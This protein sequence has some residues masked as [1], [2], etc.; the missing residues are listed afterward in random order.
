[1]VFILGIP[2]TLLL[3]TVPGLCIYSLLEDEI[4]NSFSLAVRWAFVLATSVTL[5]TLIMVLFLLMDIFPVEW[6]AVF[7]AVLLVVWIVWRKIPWQDFI[8]P[9]SFDSRESR[10]KIIAAVLVF[11]IL[12]LIFCQPTEYYFGGRDPGIYAGTAVQLSRLGRLKVEDPLLQG[13]KENYPD[14]F[15]DV[16]LKFPG[17]FMERHGDRYY[18]NPQFFHGYTAWLATGHRFFGFDGF[19]YMTPIL[20]L[21]SMLVIYAVVSSLWSRRTGFLTVVLLGLNIA[22]IWYARGPYSE[23]HSQLITWFS[24]F[25]IVQ[26]WKNKHDLM[27]L[28][29]GLTIGTALLVRLDNIFVA[30]PVGLSL[31]FILAYDKGKLGRWIW[32]FILSLA[33]MYLIF[34]SYALKF[35]RDYAKHLLILRSPI[36]NSLSLRNLFILLGALSV[37][38]VMIVI[39]LRNQW[40]KLI[41]WL[42]G[43]RKPIALVIGVGMVLL[44]G[45]LYFVRPLNPNRNLLPEGYYSFR[46]ESLV[47]LGWYISP[48]G[49]LLAL[50]GFIDFI[51]NKFRKQHIFPMLFMLTFCTMY[52]YNPRI[53]PDHFWAVRRYVPMIIPSFTIFMAYALDRISRLTVGKIKL[54]PLSLAVT[55]LLCIFLIHEARPFL[56]HTEYGGTRQGVEELASYFDE[57]DLIITWDAQVTPRL[58]GTPLYL[59]YGKN[60]LTVG[61]SFNGENLARFIEDKK[62]EGWD[63]YFL[64]GLDDT[65]M[66]ELPFHLEYKDT[67]EFW[68][69]SAEVVEDRKPEN[70]FTNI[71]EVNIYEPVEGSISWEDSLE[72]GVIDIGNPRDINYRL[73]GFYG[74][75]SSG[76][77]DYRWSGPRALVELTLPEE[78][79]VSQAKSLTIRGRHL[80]PPDVLTEK[81]E[82]IVN[83]QSI[84]SVDMG[85]EFQEYTLEIPENLLEGEEKI[86]IEFIT[87][88]WKPQELGMGADTR[89][90]GFMLDYIRFED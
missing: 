82:V 48:L 24:I 13:L 30:I 18:T 38:G 33:A 29:A 77:E 49:I 90:L 72:E 69:T 65:Y 63:V 5:T 21:I 64:L 15:K 47:R 76:K 4:R 12:A 55:A 20:A 45:W 40:A 73:E 54:K 66:G 27:A 78:Y 22:Q 9:L 25:L 2:L 67:V 37:V 71:W 56:H 41:Q 53:F 1:M 35:N 43:R 26:A 28:L 52:L 68:Y 86:T 16:H 83:G 60:V 89:D 19:L 62:A 79:D 42:R 75:E 32:T 81:V 39:L 3:L 46:E 84:G 8:A 11:I 6:L 34:V 80:L 17:V 58:A 61:E 50:G 57:N 10:I 74:A 88:T 36:P 70:V 7:Y 59:M 23:I 31:I 44:F 87:N 51:H 85:E 14:V